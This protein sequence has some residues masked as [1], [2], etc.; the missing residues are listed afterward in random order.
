MDENTSLEEYVRLRKPKKGFISNEI[1]YSEDDIL[2]HDE[3]LCNNLKIAE[4]TI[5]SALNAIE[6][7]NNSD[8]LDDN[9]L[10]KDKRDVQH[11]K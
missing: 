11:R 3:T 1:V 9:E 4:N 8:F 2:S 5:D 10:K 7:L 6:N